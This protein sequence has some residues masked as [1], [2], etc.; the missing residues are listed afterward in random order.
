MEAAPGAPGHP[1]A[2]SAGTPGAQGLHPVYRCLDCADVEVAL[3]E[4]VSDIV[5]GHIV[6][7]QHVGL[8]ESVISKLVEYNLVGR[9]VAQA[10]VRLRACIL[11]GAVLPVSHRANRQG[12]P[13]FLP[14]RSK[15]FYHLENVLAYF[16]CG[17]QAPSEEALRQLVAVC[18]HL[19]RRQRASHAEQAVRRT[20]PERTPKRDEDMRVLAPPKRAPCLVGASVEIG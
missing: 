4:P 13:H 12:D 9:E 10:G 3:Q 17:L 19:S 8:K 7:V 5:N 15:V 18:H 1:S 6:G 2:A 20:E 14:P 16:G 11:H